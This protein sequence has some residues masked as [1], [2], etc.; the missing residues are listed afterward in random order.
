MKKTIGILFLIICYA[1]NIAAQGYVRGK[2]IDG[3]TGESLIGATVAIPGTTKGTITDFDGNYSLTLDPGTYALSISYVSYE[4]QQFEEV[5]VVDG[6]VTIINANLG[7]ATTELEAV[8]VT[9]RSRQQTESALQVM[10]RKSAGSTG[11]YATSPAYPPGY[12]YATRAS[13]PLPRRDSPMTS[14]PA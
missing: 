5:E 1:F 2:I 8:V 3:E 11:R 13:A 7:E 14:V 10:Q 12:T 6:E 9:A 4:T